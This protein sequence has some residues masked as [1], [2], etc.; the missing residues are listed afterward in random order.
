M[1]ILT[2]FTCRPACLT[3]FSRTAS[4]ACRGSTTGPEIHE[5]WLLHRFVDHIRANALVEGVLDQIA[6]RWRRS[7]VAREG[8]RLIIANPADIPSPVIVKP[9]IVD[10]G[11][12]RGFCNSQ[13]YGPL[14]HV[15]ASG[16]NGKAGDRPPS[17]KFAANPGNASM[18]EQPEAVHACNTSRLWCVGSRFFSVSFIRGIAH[19]DRDDDAAVASAVRTSSPQEMAVPAL[20]RSSSALICPARGQVDIM[21]AADES[22]FRITQLAIKVGGRLVWSRQAGSGQPARPSCPPQR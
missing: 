16:Q 21:F 12:P 5:H 7:R 10:M 18:P 4:I 1:F 17:Q 15:E 14:P 13:R 22:G 19:A 11:L 3:T 6:P 8:D 20:S 9:E 2:S